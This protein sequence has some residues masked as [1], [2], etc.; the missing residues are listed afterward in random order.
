MRLLDA[1][2]WSSLQVAL[3]AGLLCS[4]SARAMTGDW[5]PVAAALAFCGTLVVYNVDRLRDLARD[6]QTSPARSAFVA[7]HRRALGTLVGMAGVASL[8]LGILLG[9][10]AVLAL[11]PVLVLRLLHRRLKR[12]VLAKPLY[13]A[14]AWVGATVVLPAV[15][16]PDPQGVTDAAWMVGL[17]ILANVIACNVRDGEAA[18]AAFG[19]GVPLRL[20][21]ATAFGGM[22]IGLLAPVAIRPLVL[23]PVTT[24]LALVPFRP[25]E[26]YGHLV[27]DGA[28][29]VGAL[30]AALLLA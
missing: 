2:A 16:R 1:L 13:I 18:S 8:G 25:T 10:R 6:R 3:A 5:Q 20:A 9:P 28:L 30:G 12:Y 11:V 23:V 14:L 27:V 26:R 7:R 4:V 15:V 24:L 22:A 17:T 29:I 21:R 19:E